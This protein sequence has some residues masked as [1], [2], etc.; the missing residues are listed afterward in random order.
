MIFYV[1]TE[2]HAFT[3][4][5]YLESWGRNLLP[6]VRP[7]FYEQLDKI[8]SLPAGTYIFSDLERLSPEESEMAAQVWEQERHL[9]HQALVQQLPIMLMLLMEVVLLQELP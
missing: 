5:R 8:K 7:V 6:Q 3:I 1:V 2:K 4:N 9:L